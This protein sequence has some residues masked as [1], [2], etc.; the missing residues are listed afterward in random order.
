M[1]AARDLLCYEKDSPEANPPIHYLAAGVLLNTV[2]GA[3][4]GTRL[5]FLPVSHHG[6]E[7]DPT[8]QAGFRWCQTCCRMMGVKPVPISPDA[9]TVPVE[10][11]KKPKAKV[12]H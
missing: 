10:K 6:R 5:P 11:P 12:R 1:E 3:A 7:S 9:A 4:P 2:C 8:G